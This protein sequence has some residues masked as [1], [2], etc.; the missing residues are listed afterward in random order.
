[1]WRALTTMTR[2]S[3][4]GFACPAML[5][6]PFQFVDFYR[7]VL[8]DLQAA[9]W[10]H[11]RL[12]DGSPLHCF[13][14]RNGHWLFLHGFYCEFSQALLWTVYDGLC[15]L[16]SHRMKHEV[17]EMVDALADCFHHTSSPILFRCVVQQVH[18][19]TCGTVAILYLGIVVGNLKWTLNLRKFGSFIVIC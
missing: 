6:P 14:E 3:N 13:F 10:G 11:F 16:Q 7:F 5:V 15:H 1:M 19:T 17:Q 8:P 9:G 2:S 4:S 18:P 12:L